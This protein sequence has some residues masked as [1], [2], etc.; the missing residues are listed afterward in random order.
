MWDFN[1]SQFDEDEWWTKI[2]IPEFGMPATVVQSAGYANWDLTPNATMEFTRNDVMVLKNLTKLN[3]ISEDTISFL[4]V[5]NNLTVSEISKSL[6][7]MVIHKI[8]QLSPELNFVGTSFPL[9]IR[10]NINQTKL[11]DN[12]IN[13]LLMLPEAIVMTNKQ[14]GFGLVYLKIPPHF[15]A[16]LYDNIIE[17]KTNNPEQDI[18]IVNFTR[19]YIFSRSF[20]VS[21]LNFSIKT[22]EAKLNE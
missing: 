14:A 16:E 15:V 18:E 21:Q 8:F 19:P 7:Q 3:Y 9:F 20:D 12:V 17:F 22:T 10:F 6:E 4:G 13:S 1:A 11:L 2:H 5:D